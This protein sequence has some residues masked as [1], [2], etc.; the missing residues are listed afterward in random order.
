[1][2]PIIQYIE[3]NGQE[4]EDF[5][6]EIRDNFWCYLSI[7][8]GFDDEE[9]S[10]DFGFQVGT[11]RAFDHR[12][13]HEGPIWG[14]HHLIVNFFDATEI[15]TA[16]EKKVAECARSTVEETNLILSRF[17]HWEFEDYQA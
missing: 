11:P 9:G 3:Q 8:I 1:M 6:P 12:G 5:N 10:S 17:F 14:R 2:K 7:R 13:Q 16:V 4:L 15:R